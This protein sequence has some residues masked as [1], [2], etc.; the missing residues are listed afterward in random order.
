MFAS[1][2][3]AKPMSRAN[4]KRYLKLLESE[5]TNRRLAVPSDSRTAA[6]LAQFQQ[7]FAHSCTS[8]PRAPLRT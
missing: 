3:A 5:T 1:G 7:R 8:S 6:I 2:A 4:S